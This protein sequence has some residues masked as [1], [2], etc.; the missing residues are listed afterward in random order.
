V[1]RSFTSKALDRAGFRVLMAEDGY[2]ALEVFRNDP[3][4]IAVVLLDLTMPAMNGQQ[5]LA[6]LR[7]IRPGVCVVA[8]SGYSQADASQRFAGN[9]Q[10]F[11][12]KPYSAKTLVAAIRTVLQI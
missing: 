7:T 6:A 2:R 8:S 11:V 12:Q 4:G 9:L 10:G 3:D 1:V 5:T